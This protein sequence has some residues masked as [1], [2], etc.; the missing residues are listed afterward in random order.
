[1]TQLNAPA[2]TAPAVNNAPAAPAAPASSPVAAQTAKPDATPATKAEA[3]PAEDK[4]AEVKVNTDKLELDGLRSGLTLKQLLAANVEEDPFYFKPLIK[5]REPN[6][7]KETGKQKVGAS[8][9]KLWKYANIT[10]VVNIDPAHERDTLEGAGDF[11][12]G[13]VLSKILGNMRKNDCEE[14]MDGEVIQMDKLLEYFD[15]PTPSALFD[16][17]ATWHKKSSQ[18]SAKAT[19][20]LAACGIHDQESDKF[21]AIYEST[22]AN[23]VE[24]SV[25]VA[26]LQLNAPVQKAVIRAYKFLV[27]YAKENKMKGAKPTMPNFKTLM[28][29][30]VKLQRH[31]AKSINDSEDRGVPE[32]E[33]EATKLIHSALTHLNCVAEGCSVSLDMYYT[34]KAKRAAAK[35]AKEGGSN[36]PEDLSSVVANIGNLG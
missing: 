20:A 33:L 18:L 28:S 19:K 1:M 32:S 30:L 13:F 29:V 8:G 4:K 11:A 15:A 27:N 7:D 36:A 16:H 2:A 24:K 31:L 22:L 12:T 23:V 10:A 5:R 6:I 14:F 25:G 26:S 34:A 21:Q 17:F 9:N 3:K 35:A